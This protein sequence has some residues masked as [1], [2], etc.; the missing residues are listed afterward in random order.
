MPTE[1]D[2][3]GRK[4]HFRTPADIHADSVLK[5]LDPIRTLGKSSAPTLFAS[6]FSDA[7]RSDPDPRHIH[8]RST[9][10]QC[11]GS[12]AGRLIHSPKSSRHAVFLHCTVDERLQLKEFDLGCSHWSHSSTGSRGDAPAALC[13]SDSI[14]PKSC[15]S[16]YS[17]HG[18]IAYNPSTS[19]PGK[20]T[21]HSMNTSGPSLRKWT[22]IRKSD[23][24]KLQ[25]STCSNTPPKKLKRV[26]TAEELR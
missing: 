5:K 21:G 20:G 4:F 7:I 25:G 9:I 17:R 19:A 6:P 11:P 14:T 1:F 10:L 26:D 2:L 18:F 22:N 12:F 24:A 13:S 23:I 3:H 8:S 16:T 15:R